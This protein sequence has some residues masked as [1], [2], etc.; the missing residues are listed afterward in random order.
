MLKVAAVLHWLKGACQDAN[1]L[2]T[3]LVAN[4]KNDWRNDLQIRPYID[5]YVYM[6]KV[7]VV[8]HWLK[9]ACQDA[10]VLK[11]VIVAHLEQLQP[12]LNICSCCIKYLQSQALCPQWY[13]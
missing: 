10:N 6:L 3:V 12:A 13:A 9:S 5:L 7:A 4:W 1:V 11:T 8:L 2:K